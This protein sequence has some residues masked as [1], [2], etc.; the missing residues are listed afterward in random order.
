V[1]KCNSSV[2]NDEKYLFACIE[3]GGQLGFR[4]YR[5]YRV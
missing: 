4:V 3:G 1:I 5:V 2:I